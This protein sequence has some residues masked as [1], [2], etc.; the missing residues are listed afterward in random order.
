MRNVAHR[1]EKH[2]HMTRSAHTCLADEQGTY[3]RA[4]IR[5]YLVFGGLAFGIC[6]Y[7]QLSCDAASTEYVCKKA[8][9]ASLNMALPSDGPHCTPLG[10]R[11]LSQTVLAD[12][13]P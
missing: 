1:A 10:T 7:V 3:V 13:L 5:T 8:T 11:P 4:Y 12:R 6:T 9:G 2:A